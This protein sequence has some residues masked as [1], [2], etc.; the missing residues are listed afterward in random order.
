MDSTDYLMGVSGVREEFSLG[1]LKG[2]TIFVD[3]II[4]GGDK[5]LWSVLSSGSFE[6]A[7]DGN[8]EGVRLVDGDPLGV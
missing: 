3:R 5:G 6:C 4:L 7:Y 2:G 8:L 1:I